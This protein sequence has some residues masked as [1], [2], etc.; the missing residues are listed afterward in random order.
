MPEESKEKRIGTVDLPLPAPVLTRKDKR[1]PRFWGPYAKFVTAHYSLIPANQVK[2][3]SP[4]TSTHPT[5]LL[6][7]G[8][9]TV[10]FVL[11]FYVERKGGEFAF[12]AEKM[13]FELFG[14]AKDFKFCPHLVCSSS[15][16]ELIESK[17]VPTVPV[18]VGQTPSPSHWRWPFIIMTALPGSTLPCLLKYLANR[19][20]QMLILAQLADKLRLLRELEVP[21]ND[22][23]RFQPGFFSALLKRNKVKAIERHRK[24]KTLPALLIDQLEEYLP[25]DV[26]VFLQGVSYKFVHGDITDSNIL[27]QADSSGA[28]ELTGIVDFGDA[29]MADPLYE[30]VTIHTSL[31]NF[32][33]LL[34]KRFVALTG[35]QISSMKDFVYRCSVYQLMNEFNRLNT[36]DLGFVIDWNGIHSLEDMANAMWNLDDMSTMTP[37][38]DA[39][40]SPQIRSH[41]ASLSYNASV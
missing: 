26:D 13:L 4:H 2:V 12:R 27:A 25:Q 22:C 16:G 34:L 24:W 19:S 21:K 3:R 23:P 33:K 39:P 14:K 7:E 5:F 1:S 6:A 30:L 32:D 40:R 18:T 10:K 31:L 20:N 41:R 29:L 35:M 38:L 11:K 15:L 37:T 9:G 28:L 36:S 8:D 17:K